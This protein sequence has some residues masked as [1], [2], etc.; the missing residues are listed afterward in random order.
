[1]NPD[2]PKKYTSIFQT[3][4]KIV[5]EEGFSKLY[6]SNG[7]NVLRVIP[8]YSLR[9][10]FN[11]Q[12]KD[13][14][15]KPGQTKPLSFSQMLAAGSLA[16]CS[17][18]LLTYPLELIRTRLALSSSQSG[19]IV[20]KG[21][22]DCGV[23]TYKIEGFKG[24]YKGVVPTVLSGT[25]YIGFQ[26]TFYDFFKDLFVKDG[27]SS[28]TQTFWKLSA[29]AGVAAQTVTYPGDTVRRRMQTNGMGGQEQIYKGAMDAVFKIAKKEGLTAFFKGC[30]ANITAAIP[31]AAIQ[32]YAYEKVKHLLGL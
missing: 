32:F 15:R 18:I 27:Q 5:Q 7:A 3:G 21:I 16:G 13:L 26:M 17:Q 23:S 8:L 14:V 2:A 12:F 24:L 4:Q 19:S 6:K 20:Y 10:M 31:G 22:I 30:G 29:L 9:F 11:D 28:Q 25:P 1:V